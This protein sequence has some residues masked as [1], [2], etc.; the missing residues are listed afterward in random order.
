MHDNEFPPR[1]SAS[2]SWHL[3]DFIFYEEAAVLMGLGNKPISTEFCYS[4]KIKCKEAETLKNMPRKP[5]LIMV[6]R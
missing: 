3:F 1:P 6:L 5:S 2:V 4:K